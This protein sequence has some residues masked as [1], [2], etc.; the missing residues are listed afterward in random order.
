MLLTWVSA[1][2]RECGGALMAISTLERLLHSLNI[3]SR[4]HDNVI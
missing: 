2:L 3:R 4:S 1:P